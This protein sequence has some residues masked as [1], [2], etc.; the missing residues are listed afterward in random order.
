M[1]F[2][3]A[4]NSR[5]RLTC[6]GLAASST[7]AAAHCRYCPVLGHTQSPAVASIDEITLFHQHPVLITE[8]PLNPRKN[9]GKTAEVFFESFN[10]PALYV[11]AQAILSLYVALF[12]VSFCFVVR[13]L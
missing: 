4:L 9:R 1:A 2:Y 8:A 10:V 7:I 13:I 11:A 12:P 3:D 6:F 5:C